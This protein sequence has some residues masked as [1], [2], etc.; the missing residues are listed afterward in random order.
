MLRPGVPGR[1]RDGAGD[2]DNC[3]KTLLDSLQVPK[4]NQLAASDVPAS[5]ENPLYCLVED[6]KLITRL[7]VDTDRLLVESK[8]SNE[9]LVLIRVTLEFTHQHFTNLVPPPRL[10]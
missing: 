6:D 2:L 3:L 4:A 10:V 8:S 5:D 9:V 1:V 7:G